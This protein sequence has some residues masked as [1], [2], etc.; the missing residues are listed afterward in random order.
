MLVK[1]DQFRDAVETTGAAS[2]FE[3]RARGDA[4]RGES[5]D[6]GEIKIAKLFVVRSVEKGGA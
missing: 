4:I 5:G 6:T 2:D 1:S 3:G